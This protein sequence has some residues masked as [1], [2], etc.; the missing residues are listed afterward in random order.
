MKEKIEMKT[1]R[2]RLQLIVMQKDTQNAKKVAIISLG[3]KG[4]RY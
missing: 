4:K 3:K 2:Q 1:T